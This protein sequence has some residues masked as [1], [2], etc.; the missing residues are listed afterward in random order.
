MLNRR[1]WQLCGRARP[2]RGRVGRTGSTTQCP[3]HRRLL[4]AD[5]GERLGGPL[6]D[7]DLAVGLTPCVEEHVHGYEEKDAGCEHRG[8]AG[9]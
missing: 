1:D 2:L 8:E 6:G 9:C 4:A 3:L 5:A 7:R